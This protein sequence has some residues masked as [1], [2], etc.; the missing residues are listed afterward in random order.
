MNI[1]CESCGGKNSLPKG[2]T[3]MFCSFCGTNIEAPTKQT[4]TKIR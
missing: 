2:K 1:T 3:S 4:K